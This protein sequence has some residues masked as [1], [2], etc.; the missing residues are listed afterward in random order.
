[1][2]KKWSTACT[3]KRYLQEGETLLIQGEQKTAIEQLTKAI[4]LDPTLLDAYLNRAIIYYEIGDAENAIADLD[5]VLRHKPDVPAAYYWRGRAYMHL[6]KTDLALADINQAIELDPDEPA[7]PLFRAFVHLCREE[8]ETAVEDN[9]KAIQLGFE[10]EGYSNRA[11]VLAEIGNSQAAIEDWT[12][13]IA[14]NP[15]D[16]SAYCRRGILLEKTGQFERALKDLKT[17]LENKNDLS[18][19]LKVK[20]EKLLD[21]LEKRKR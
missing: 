14:L 1:M 12:R 10:E 3:A 2:F 17:G 13:V 9:T 20:S 18:E 8:Y 5:H 4:E 15:D 19:S 7:N 6:G 16:A 21:K 11:L